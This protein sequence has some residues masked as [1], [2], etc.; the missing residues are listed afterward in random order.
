MTELTRRQMLFG[1]AAAAF[2]AAV[3][4]APSSPVGAAAP[5]AGRQ[6]PGFY[7]YK[8]GTIEVTVVTDGVIRFPVTDGL[9]LNARKDEVNAALAAAFMEKDVYV[10]PFNPIV[11]N[12][13]AKLAVI[14]T[15]TGEAAYRDSQ[16]ANGQ[17]LTNLAAAGIDATRVDAVIISH[18]HV[19]HISGLL[20][21]DD[22]LAFPNAE[23]LVPELEHKYWMDDGEMSRASTPRIEGVF[24]NV[25][26]VMRGEVLKRLRTYT[27]DR[28]VIPGVVATGTPGHTPGHTCHIVTSGANK[29][30]VQGDLTHAPF[31]FVR[32]P[33]WHPFVDH[34]PVQ[35]EAT[36]RKVYDMLVAEKMPVQG[37][38]YPFPA[39]AHVEKT[40]TGYREIPVAWN[41]TI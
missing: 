31:L 5:A 32:N 21:I 26:R 28:E 20:K 11:V 13:G 18:Y 7:R 30:Y 10:T 38:H 4:F 19:D 33:G 12:T 23:I 41:P 27:W 16:G 29:V 39:L 8:V 25:R 14:D 24:K 22:S 17:F 15:G 36:R 40:A 1:T 37:F 34:D 35:A 2:A 6:A 3:P 9:V